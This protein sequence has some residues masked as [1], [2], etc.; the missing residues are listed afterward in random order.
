MKKKKH[1]NKNKNGEI[2]GCNEEESK[3][4]LKKY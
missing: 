3:Q 4:E 2:V 1:D